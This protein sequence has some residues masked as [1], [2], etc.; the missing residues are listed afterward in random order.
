M[1]LESQL[2]LLW[3]YG[4]LSASKIIISTPAVAIMKQIIFA[5]VIHAVIICCFQYALC[6]MY[7]VL[8]ILLCSVQY[9][10]YG[11]QIK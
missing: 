5:S 1:T 3:G 7:N 10:L 8:S 11:F 2:S 9:N 6:A 4:K